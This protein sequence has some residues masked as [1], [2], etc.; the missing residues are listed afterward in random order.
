MYLLKTVRHS[1]P[2]LDFW[3]FA[4]S[5]H[6][7]GP[8]VTDVFEAGKKEAQVG[9]MENAVYQAKRSANLQVT[10]GGCGYQEDRPGEEGDGSLGPRTVSDVADPDL[11]EHLGPDGGV[12][13]L[14]LVD[15][16]G[17]ELDYLGYAAPR[18]GSPRVVDGRRAP[19]RR[20]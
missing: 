11:L 16:L 10:A 15:A 5:L 13:F 3:V 17:L 14:I 19:S 18:V 20:G 2:L 8:V 7:A 12:N 4:H 1:P 9:L 6:I